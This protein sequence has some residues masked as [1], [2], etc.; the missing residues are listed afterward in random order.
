MT[1]RLVSGV[2]A[3]VLGLTA[4]TLPALATTMPVVA[5]QAGRNHFS[6]GVGG[7]SVSLDFGLSNQFSLGASAS[8]TYL[9]RRSTTRSAW[10]VP[11]MDLRGVYQLVEG[12][13]RGLSVG[14]IF[15]VVGDPSEPFASGDWGPELGIGLSYPFTPMITGRANIVGA[16]GWP[17]RLFAAP[18]AGLELAFR[19]L[20]TMEL[21]IAANGNGDILGLRFTF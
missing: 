4:G 15:G 19:L 10:Y 20:P 11:R 7:P 2:I 9:W 13:N 21:A 16:G 1:K 6:F 8:L 17:N 5:V 14:V 18:A 12:G 3:T